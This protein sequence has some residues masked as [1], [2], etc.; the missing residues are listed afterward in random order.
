M[1]VVVWVMVRG[2]RLADLVG[3]A[4]ERDTVRARVAVHPDVAVAGLGVA[5][6]NQPGQ[7]V[8]VADQAGPLSGPHACANG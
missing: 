4:G 3:E 1:P 6:Q 2:L 7:F 8:A 5:L